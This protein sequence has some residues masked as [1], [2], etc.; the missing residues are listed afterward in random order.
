MVKGIY[1]I[2]LL[3]SVF[4]VWGQS[5]FEDSVRWI[6]VDNSESNAV[7]FEF[8][9]MNDSTLFGAI[10]KGAYYGE[11]IF[12]LES[13]DISHKVQSY[14][15]L[16]KF[17]L[18]DSLK[19]D[20]CITAYREIYEEQLANAIVVAFNDNLPLTNS[21]GDVIILDCG[22][23]MQCFSYPPKTYNVIPIAEIKEIRVKEIREFNSISNQYEYKPIAVLLSPQLVGKVDFEI[24]CDLSR[25]NEKSPDIS[26]LDWFR[27]ITSKEFTGVQ[28][29]Q[30][31][32]TTNIK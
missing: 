31:P 13:K 7:L 22:G 30:L 24:W 12:F 9:G 29:M 10:W 4:K 32:S 5:S 16:I 17:P 2:I 19:V 21:I 3:L 27:F 15:A 18:I 23:G 6:R 28:F 25:L 11:G 14:P 20:S 1:T 26:E 8:K